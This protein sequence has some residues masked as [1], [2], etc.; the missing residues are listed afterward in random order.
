M[1]YASNMQKLDGC[2]DSVDR[3]DS[4]TVWQEGSEEITK[5]LFIAKQ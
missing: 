2:Y 4:A 1:N 3:Y 5:N